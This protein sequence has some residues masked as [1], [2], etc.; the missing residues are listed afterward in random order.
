M[1]S[2]IAHLA[3]LS[4]RRSTDDESNQKH[5]AQYEYR[6][7]NDP[8]DYDMRHLQLRRIRLVLRA[9]PDAEKRP[10]HRFRHL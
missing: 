3:L 1:L 2:A 4:L 10:E 5:K 9:S 8:G 7:A 6:G